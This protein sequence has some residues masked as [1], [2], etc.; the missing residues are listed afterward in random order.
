MVEH[1]VIQHNGG[2][3]PRLMFD[4]SIKVIYKC[5]DGSWRGPWFAFASPDRFNKDGIRWTWND[6]P[7]DVIEYRQ[8]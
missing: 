6:G 5:R 3:F 4:D 1:E 8:V 2:K 7:N